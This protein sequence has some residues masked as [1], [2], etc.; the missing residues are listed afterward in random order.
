M[1]FIRKLFSTTYLLQFGADGRSR[2]GTACAT[3]PS[4]RR[5]YQFH[6]IGYFTFSPERFSTEAIAPQQVHLPL[7]HHQ[8]QAL[9]TVSMAR[10]SANLSPSMV[11]P[12]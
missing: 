2:T 9:A 11:L 7:A 4:R 1:I 3:A 5:V 8:R 12:S 10:L 6:H